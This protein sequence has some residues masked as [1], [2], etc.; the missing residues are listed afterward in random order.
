[1]RVLLLVSLLLGGMA[2]AWKIAR[3]LGFGKPEETGLEA[4]RRFLN[5]D[6]AA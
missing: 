1:M 4:W 6:E 5:D 2:L 3:S